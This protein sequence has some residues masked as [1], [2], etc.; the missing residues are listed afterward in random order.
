MPVA[1]RLLAGIFLKNRSV[2]LLELFPHRSAPLKIFVPIVWWLG[3]S[4]EPRA[5][6]PAAKGPP[7]KYTQER[8]PGTFALRVANVTGP[9]LRAVNLAQRY[10]FVVLHTF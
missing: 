2:P 10:F 6:A 1:Q 4:E 9:A 7:T 5:A 3:E 8:S